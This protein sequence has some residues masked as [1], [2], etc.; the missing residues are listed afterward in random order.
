MVSHP[1]T[2]P[3]NVCPTTEVEQHPTSGTK[4]PLV[5]DGT[6]FSPCNRQRRPDHKRWDIDSST[7]ENATIASQQQSHERTQIL[8]PEAVAMCPWQADSVVDAGSSYTVYQECPDLEVMP[9]VGYGHRHNLP[10]EVAHR[11]E[12][13]YPVQYS[14]TAFG[15]RNIGPIV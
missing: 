4:G 7:S 14:L 12:T 15:A 9:F 10:E 3:E 2:G 6:V 1:T 11:Y 13:G 5:V 8:N